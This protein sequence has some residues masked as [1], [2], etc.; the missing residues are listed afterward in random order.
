MKKP[1][2]LLG[3]ILF[4]LTAFSADVPAPARKPFVSPIFADHMVLQR[5]KP[6]TLWGWTEPGS[7]VRIQ[8]ANQVSRAT[9]GQD[10]QWALSFLPPPAG[11]P[12]VLRIDGPETVELRD[13]LVGDVWICA[14]Q[15]NMEIGVS[16][17]TDG[18]KEIASANHPHIR[19]YQMPGQV[20]YA[21]RETAGGGWQ[22]CTPE[23]VRGGGSGGFSAVGYFFGR[24]LNQALDVPIG[25]IQCAVG[26]TPAETWAS[27]SSLASLGGFDSALADL[28]DLRKKAAPEY[29]NFIAHWY[30]AFDTGQR[31]A[32][33]S[34]DF[35]D[36][37]W[38]PVTLTGGFKAL[39][40]PDTPAV[41]YFRRTLELPATLPA[42][43][44]SFRLGIVERMDT[45][46]ING[47]QIGA[48]AWVENPRAYPIPDGVL[49]PGSNSVVIR[50]FKTR[51]DGG[52]KSPPETL[53]IVMGD[54]TGIP[55]E[56]NW[57]G[58]VAVDARQPH[59]LPAGFENWPTMP[60]VLYNGMIAPLSPLAISGAIWYQGE[61]N[62]GRAAQYR[63]LLP[64][65]IADWRRLF[66][67]GDFP[68]YIVS[69]ASFTPRRVT[70]GE[71]AWAELREA[72]AY[73]ADTVPGA[74]L[75]IAIDRGAVDDIHPKDKR[76]IGERLALLALA[77]HY[78]QPRSFSGPVFRS[79]DILP[80]AIRLHFD[81]VEGGLTCVAE[82]L[83]EFSIRGSDGVWVWAEARLDGET[84]I[85]SSPAVP[86]PEAVRYAW[87]ANPRATLV[88]A[89]GL[90]AVPFRTDGP[91]AKP[92][93]A[94]SPATP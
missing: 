92:L 40:V 28:E 18:A 36:R 91:F 26:G 51:P 89:A 69:L 54:G 76:E 6:N 41:T 10:G 22:V 58:R 38:Q 4:A 31:E 53:R 30:D 9:A 66:R 1:A 27:A 8:I 79:A 52:F 86:H 5:N 63:T 90:P 16:R 56:G 2:A 14:G 37:G 62:V 64:T 33:H 81:H 12:Y 78:G 47:R 25:L 24:E 68:F 87:Q 88:N 83:E 93:H 7:E 84:V 44:A 48:S 34:I 46:W 71:D 70:P 50:V 3:F 29:G 42:E 59:P 21:P 49:H 75:A 67:Q 45:V 32:W 15:S 55:L 82:K 73:T 85:V 57:K 43:K 19:L 77:K 23:T 61:A 35:D 39:G 60:S 13:I 94:Q 80:G 17:T 65:L 72:Q 74:G 20:A 11:G